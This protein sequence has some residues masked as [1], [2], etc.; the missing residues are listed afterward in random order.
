[1]KLLGFE[2][3]KDLFVHDDDFKKAYDNYVVSA[4]GCFFQHEGFLFKEKYLCVPKKH[5]QR[6][7]SMDDPNL[8]TNSF[9]E[10]KYGTNWGD[11]KQSK[12]DIML[13]L[14]DGLR[15]HVKP[16]EGPVM[17]LD[18]RCLLEDSVEDPS[19]VKRVHKSDFNQDQSKSSIMESRSPKLRMSR[20][21]QEH[22]DPIEASRPVEAVL[23]KLAFP[24]KADFSG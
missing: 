22:S 14:D 19:K 16:F 13:D 12:E 11:H 4:N 9:Q 6:T 10:E 3:L 2:S 24:A 8:R 15:L 5:N 23:A 20:P 7:V 1:M 21:N 18:E 17:P